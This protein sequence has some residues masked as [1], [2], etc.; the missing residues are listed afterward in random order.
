MRGLPRVY[1]LTFSSGFED[2]VSHF[3]ADKGPL[4][5]PA[6]APVATDATAVL[7]AALAFSLTLDV[8]FRRAEIS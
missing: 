3:L 6:D 2:G 1:M 5:P 4:P 7:F 8:R